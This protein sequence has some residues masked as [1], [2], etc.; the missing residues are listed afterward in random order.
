MCMSDVPTP[1]RGRPRSLRL[2]LV[3]WY[4]AL[5]AVALGL[6]VV[7]VLV[8]AM[9]AI[10]Q[11]VDGDVQAEARIASLD[12][13]N[14]LSAIPPYWSPELSLN[15]ID[16]YRDPG[17]VVEVLDTQ[18]HIHYYSANSKDARVPISASTTRVVL[19]GQIT[20][21]TATAGDER[22]RVEALPVRAPIIGTSSNGDGARGG[23][24]NIIGMLVVA[25]SMDDVDDTFFL[26]R[27]LL[28]IAGLVIL[29]GALAGGWVIATQVLHPLTE[30]VLTAR[31]IAANARGT[32]IGGL[33][34]R[35]RRP[36]GR[37]EMTQVVDTFN[38]MLA[39]LE[40]VTSAQR[41]FVADASHELRAPLTTIQGNLAFLQR[42]VDELP[43]EER[44]TMLTDA[45]EETL[46]LAR[47]V[48]DL[49]LLARAD[50]SAEMPIAMRERTDKAVAD[51]TQQESLLE[52]DHAVLHLVRQLSR[53]LSVE[54]SRLKLEVGRIEPVKVWGDE[55][56][57]R[58][59]TL[60]LLDNAIKYTS[61][62]DEAGAGRI[63]VSLERVGK[64]AVLQIRDN[65]IGIDAAD[66]PHIF[67]RFYRADRAR[68]RQGTGLGLSIARTLMEQFGGR[69]TAESIPGQ[70]STF[71]VWLPL[72]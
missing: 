24:T 70:G 17:I 60:I 14:S 41:R 61:T 67:E 12:V 69:I 49:L 58:R 62:T 9:N 45:Y 8:L 25:K 2:R 53:R 21:F 66:L 63:K 29:L 16:I 20:W 44:R 72:A 42:H 28:L 35:V 4:G 68:S 64:E 19:A 1:D 65:G 6:F 52:L 54:G 37:D 5:L 39:A 31:T 27:T 3:L 33:S 22:V 51:N 43:T 23:Q 36:P 15:V 7:L 59:V 18:G 11:S 40:N 48:E 56:S 47:L 13:R 10:S 57:L 38:E 71:S 32:R 50:A 30:I 55:E 26:L 34:R 46:Q